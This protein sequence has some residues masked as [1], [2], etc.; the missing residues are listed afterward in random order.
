[1]FAMDKKLGAV[2]IYLTFSGAGSLFSTMVF[3]VNLVYQVQVAHLNPLQLV[4]VG[5][6]LEGVVFLFE[7]PTGIVADLYSRRLSIIIGVLL[8]GFGYGLQGVVPSFGVILLANAIW[9]IGYTF[10]SGAEQAWI[11]D[12]VGVE[13]AGA[14]FLRGSQIELLFAV[15]GSGIA[16]AIGNFY[17]R[18]PI[19]IGGGLYLLL[20]VFLALCMP[21]HGFVP[22]PPEERASWRAL[23]ATFGRGAALVRRSPV[24]LTILGIAAFAGAA[25]E[26][27]DRLGT[28]HFLHNFTFPTL[29]HLQP[30]V[31]LGGIN[32]IGRF[33][34]IGATEVVRRRVDTTNHRAVARTL[35]IS[36]ACL[37]VSYL[38]FALVRTFPLAVLTNKGVWLFRR[39]N[40]PL[41]NA[42]LNQHVESRV[43]ATV[44]SIYGQSDAIGQ[45][46]GGPIVG[47]IGLFASVRAA[48]VVGGVILSP[49]LLLYG[50][51][52]RHDDTVAAPLEEVGVVEA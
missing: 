49:A 41:S 40:N 18:L 16:I 11:S 42:W 19:L 15:I 39:I 35:T 28:D 8:T 30:V 38:A 22:T 34:D 14:L 36:T 32:L 48:L 5:T 43:R 10:T 44:F 1:M 17:L 7:V 46:T 47:G 29:G 50:R 37:V 20:G 13:R 2:P 6:V 26:A 51:T 21:E 27:F 9:G 25:T 45:I 31:W 33:I 24:L 23:G 12:E 4:L 52:L 3:T